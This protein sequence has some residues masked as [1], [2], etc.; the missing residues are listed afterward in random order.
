MKNLEGVK[1]ESG[2]DENSY[3]IAPM[4]KMMAVR[5]FI[6]DSMKPAD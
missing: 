3:H 1:D 5:K 6:H 2:E 4:T